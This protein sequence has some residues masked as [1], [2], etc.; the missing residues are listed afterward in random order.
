MTIKLTIAITISAIISVLA[1]TNLFLEL[2]CL[3]N[4]LGESSNQAWCTHTERLI[5]AFI[6]MFFAVLSFG[7]FITREVHIQPINTTS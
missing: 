4:S 2:F 7:L 1:A 5:Y 3:G 6:S